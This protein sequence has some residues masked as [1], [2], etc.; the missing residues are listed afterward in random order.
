MKIL[1]TAFEPFGKDSV[2][3]S[4]EA[5][6]QVSPP[7]GITLIRKTV[8]TVFGECVRAAV[9]SIRMYSPDAVISLGQ[10][11]GRKAVTPEKVA[12][13]LRDARIPDNAGF[14]PKN[15]PI[16]PEA[17]AAFFSSI[18][19]LRMAERIQSA[20]IFCE[21]SNTAGTFVCNDLFFG[22]LNHLEKTHSSIPC[23]F[24]HVPCIPEQIPDDARVASMLL[25]C[26]IK[27]IE[28]A[29]TVFC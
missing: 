18:P 19:I 1:L 21:I 12:I 29:L 25:P 8:P 13:N 11:A 28:C 22:L 26:I 3:S 14:Q 20:G 10:A 5:M 17:P 6:L 24:I 27:A 23:G 2:N 7:E 15:E 4:L 16:D 9:D